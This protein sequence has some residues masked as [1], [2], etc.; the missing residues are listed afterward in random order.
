[1]SKLA[2]FILAGGQGQRLSIL[3]RHRAKPAVPFGG[4]YRIIDF[5]MT[6]C[7]RSGISHV[8]VLTQ[9]ISR[10]LVRHL[11]IGKP[12]DM[13]RREGGLRILHPRLGYKGADWYQ[14]TAD[15]IFQNISVLE[16]LKCENVLILSGDHV[17]RADYGEFL[18]VHEEQGA[19]GTMGVVEVPEYLTN[20]FG[21][22]TV[23]SDGLVTRF[24]EKPESCSSALASMGIYIFKREALISLL[25]EL[26]KIYHDLDFGKH[27]VPYL[28]GRREMAAYGFDRYWLDIGTI[29]SYFM[30]S[31]GL[32]TED[33]GFD[34][35]GENNVL[36]VPGDYLPMV[37]E[38]EAEVDNSIICSGCMIGGKVRSSIISPGVEI[39]EGAEV[40][41]SVI[42]HNCR[43]ESGAK[44]K[45]CIMDKMARI[46][47][48]SSV[49]R[50]DRSVKNRIQPEYLDSGITLIGRK[51]I[52]P[53][54]ISVGTNCVILGNEI[55]G[56]VQNR[57]YSDGDYFVPEP[58]PD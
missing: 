22:A 47:K 31:R 18:K 16:D 36:T 1:M 29:R 6:N 37:I 9:Y 55:N 10:S 20:Q 14:G 58:E 4:N 38:R 5:T 12:W 17:Y 49:G 50:G 46:G 42:F 41:D 56:A 2:A 25:K 13:D 23:G 24:D 40:E 15:A 45:N 19:T 57:D 54:G 11:G 48:D 44:V 21:I 8:Y 32:L 52:L 30:A 34:L 51:T 35:Y 28:T 3:T 43:I 26:K 33:Y 27:V 53:S 7:V 39:E